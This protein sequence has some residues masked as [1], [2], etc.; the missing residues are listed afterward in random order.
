[1][2]IKCFSLAVSK[3]QFQVTCLLW[4]VKE[5]VAHLF[6]ILTVSSCLSGALKGEPKL[7]PAGSAYHGSSAI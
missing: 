3:N 5:V 4:L 1:M 6:Q 2:I 7:E